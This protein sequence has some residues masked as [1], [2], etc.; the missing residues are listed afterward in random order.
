MTFFGRH[1]PSTVPPSMSAEQ[2]GRN[3]ARNPAG[4]PSGRK[5]ST[6]CR[7]SSTQ[8]PRHHAPQQQLCLL[9][10][11]LQRSSDLPRRWFEA[12]SLLSAPQLS[13]KLTRRGGMGLRRLR[14]SHGRARSGTRPGLRG[15]KTTSRMAKRR[16]NNPKRIPV[17]LSPILSRPAHESRVLNRSK[18]CWHGGHRPFVVAAGVQQLR[19]RKSSFRIHKGTPASMVRH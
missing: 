7:I 15:E 13:G 12:Q 6:S 5:C 3:F 14:C 16:K 1:S 4:G 18:E 17:H 8:H 19:P 11:E 2:N 9:V 10:V